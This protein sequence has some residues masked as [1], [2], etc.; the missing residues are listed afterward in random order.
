MDAPVGGR[1]ILQLARD[2]TGLGA[3]AGQAHGPGPQLEH[4]GIA[5]SGISQAIQ[6]GQRLSATFL[7]HAHARQLQISVRVLRVDGNRLQVEFAGLAA[8]PACQIMVGEIVEQLSGS[9]CN[10]Q[11]AAVVP[12]SFAVAP[13]GIEDRTIKK[14]RAEVGRML[15]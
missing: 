9:R 6:I 11:R 12:L 8:V 1:V 7:F 3:F 13:G 15:L 4:D 5:A 10:L 14:Q 2:F